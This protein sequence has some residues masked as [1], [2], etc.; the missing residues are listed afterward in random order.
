MSRFALPGYF[1][2]RQTAP[3]SSLGIGLGAKPL[4]GFKESSAGVVSRVVSRVASHVIS[5]ET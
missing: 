1:S 2:R 5:R 4:A 3:R